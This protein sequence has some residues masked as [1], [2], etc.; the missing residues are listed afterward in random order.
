ML[1]LCIQPFST[2]ANLGFFVSNKGSTG[3]EEEEKNTADQHEKKPDFNGIYEE[4]S[5]G[6]GHAK[7]LGD[8]ANREEGD[9]GVDSRQNK[10][11]SNE[12]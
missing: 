7:S 5:E 11:S 3:C 6:D 2:V 9:N 1:M 8:K 4:R 12:S 10:S